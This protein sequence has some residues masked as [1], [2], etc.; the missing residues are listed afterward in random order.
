LSFDAGGQRAGHFM[1]IALKHLLLD[2]LAGA[3]FFVFVAL[4]G[5]VTLAIAVGIGVGLIQIAIQKYMGAPIPPIQLMGLGLVVVLGGASLISNDSRFV[6]FKPSISRSA[7]GVVMLR[8]GWL[9]RYL[10]EITRKTLPAVA[11]ERAGYA[12][13]GVMFALAAVNLIVAATFSVRTWALYA[14]IGPTVVKAVA[15][16]VTYLVLRAMVNR[17]LGPPPAA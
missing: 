12:W 15:L 1:H 10:P 2:F 8:R 4:T 5:N 17:R 14:L 6:M 11:I 16:I 7:I 9:A 13:A 3:F